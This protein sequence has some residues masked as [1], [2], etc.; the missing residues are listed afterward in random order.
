MYFAEIWKSKNDFNHILF[1]YNQSNEDF[2]H[3]PLSMLHILWF[4]VEVG[5][6][7]YLKV[8]QGNEK[9]DLFLIKD[10]EEALLSFAS[11]EEMPRSRW[12]QFSALFFSKMPKQHKAMYTSVCSGFVFFLLLQYFPGSVFILILLL[13][14]YSKR[15]SQSAPV[16]YI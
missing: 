12:N 13:L 6:A 1:N 9:T 15:V 14:L 4:A 7:M 8:L 5:K 10:F 11:P 16:C 2:L 3:S